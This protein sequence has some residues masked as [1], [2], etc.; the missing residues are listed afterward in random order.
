MHVVFY[1]ERDES[2][3]YHPIS[4]W[5]I[6][7]EGNFDFDETGNA[8]NRVSL[9]RVVQRLVISNNWCLYTTGC[10]SEILITRVYNKFNLTLVA[11]VI[12]TYYLFIYSFFTGKRNIN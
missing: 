12:L 5:S 3:L 11:Y 9:L 6:N 7:F 10:S 1:T 8:I 2:P 4:K